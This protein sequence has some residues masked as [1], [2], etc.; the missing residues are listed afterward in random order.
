MS[1]TKHVLTREKHLNHLVRVVPLLCLAYGIQSYMMMSYAKGGPTGTLVLL[2]G[3]SLACSVMLLV[4]YD[5]HHRVS[6]DD[7][8]FSVSAPWRWGQQRVERSQISSI[9]VVGTEDEFQTVVVRTHQRRRYTFY[10]VDNGHEF[11]AAL[12]AAPGAMSHAA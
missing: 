4:G 10:F 1:M 6:W 9:E 5:Q 8:S 3:V 11:K 12:E 7:E 2:L